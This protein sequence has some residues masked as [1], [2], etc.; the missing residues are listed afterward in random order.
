MKSKQRLA[1]VVALAL[2]LGF[3]GIYGVMADEIQMRGDSKT[4]ENKTVK[5]ALLDDKS[6]LTANNVTFVD[7]PT[8]YDEKG[9]VGK[10]EVAVDGGSTLNMTGGAI[11]VT[12]DYFTATGG[13]VV[14]IKDAKVTSGAYANN[15][16]ITMT[17]SKISGRLFMLEMFGRKMLPFLRRKQMGSQENSRLMEVL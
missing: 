3:S 1:K 11:E 17:N 2:V 7:D 6:M 8:N 16:S 14:N 15:A 13:S 12:N 9:F 10:G 4:I 5:G